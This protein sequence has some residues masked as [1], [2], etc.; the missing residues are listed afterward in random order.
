MC[1]VREQG[2]EAGGP[3]GPDQVSRTDAVG[4][5]VREIE[6]RATRWCEAF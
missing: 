2:Q 3:G 1:E 4:E 5:E 6:R